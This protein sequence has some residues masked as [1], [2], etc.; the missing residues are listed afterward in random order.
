VRLGLGDDQILFS[1]L[2]IGYADEAAAV[3]QWPVP[4]ADIEEAIDWRGFA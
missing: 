3:N 1:G 2:A 4:R